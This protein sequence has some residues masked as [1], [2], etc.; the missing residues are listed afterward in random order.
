MRATLTPPSQAE[1]WVQIRLARQRVL[2]TA[3]C[4]FVLDESVLARPAGPAIMAEQLTHIAEVAEAGQGRRARAAV[5]SGPDY[6]AERRLVPHHPAR[7]GRLVVHLEHYR[8]A[9]FV[10]AEGDVAA[11]VAATDNLISA[12]ADPAASLGMVREYAARHAAEEQP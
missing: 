5:H 7:N 6:R 1:S 2:E 8:A 12:C 11:Y 9:V 10:F 4:T 3:R